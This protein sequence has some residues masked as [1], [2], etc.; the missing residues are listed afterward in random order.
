MPFNLGAMAAPLAQLGGQMMGQG[1]PRLKG[2]ADFMKNMGQFQN[3][4]QAFRDWRTARK[5]MAPGATKVGEFDTGIAQQP[6]GGAPQMAGAAVKSNNPFLQKPGPRFGTPPGNMGAPG[7]PG[8]SLGAAERGGA[9]GMGMPSSP[10]PPA[11]PATKFGG[12]GWPSGG[13]M[14]NNPFGGR[15]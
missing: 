8:P 6:M 14:T 11:P 12:G 4:L 2:T 1:D 13:N 9:P 5:P 7:M 15:F 10:R 3:G